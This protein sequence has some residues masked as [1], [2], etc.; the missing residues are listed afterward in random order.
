MSSPS[1]LDGLL[2]TRLQV[3]DIGRRCFGAGLSF[4]SEIIA[5]GGGTPEKNSVVLRRVSDL[6]E[7]ASFFGHSNEVYAI[8]FTPDFK[9]MASCGYD[10]TICIWDLAT[11]E[12]VKQLRVMG[13]ISKL[14][15]S[16]DGSLLAYGGR[17]LDLGFI[18]SEGW[19][20][21]IVA[22]GLNLAPVLSLQFLP[23]P[24]PGE[25]LL[26]VLGRFL[27]VL[28][29]PLATC[30]P[31]RQ[32]AFSVVVPADESFGVGTRVGVD[33][34]GEHV[35][36][37]YNGTMHY[38]QRTVSGPSLSYTVQSS[39]PDR[40]RGFGYSRIA[41]RK[42]L[43]AVV[44]D[45]TARLLRLPS[46]ESIAAFQMPDAI[47]HLYLPMARPVLLC[48]STRQIRKYNLTGLVQVRRV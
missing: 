4:D 5:V 9:Y 17:A 15:F 26:L 12:L 48:T 27:D 42:R 33:E 41:V 30:V 13:S 11:Q 36:L 2:E 45:K 6:T 47:E 16:C 44:Q 34:T 23:S 8:A 21:V 1:D 24:V 46:L 28:R 19:C 39:L 32:A 31:Q 25:A 37:Y 43:A 22:S 7:T 20:E 14:A 35:V 10:K 3:A 29:I 40:Q 18:R 38:L